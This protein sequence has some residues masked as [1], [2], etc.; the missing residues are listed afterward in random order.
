M[1]VALIFLSQL[2]IRTE[3]INKRML[4]KWDYSCNQN[5]PYQKGLAST[6]F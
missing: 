4:N 5:L 2:K 6:K 3:A 1:I